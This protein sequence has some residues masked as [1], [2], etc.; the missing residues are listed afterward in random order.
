MV[1]LFALTLEPLAMLVPSQVLCF[2]RV[3]PRRARGWQM[4][5]P[6]RAWHHSACNVCIVSLYLSQHTSGTVVSDTVFGRPTLGQRSH[7][8]TYLIPPPA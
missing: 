3:P 6:W 1:L 8:F 5:C 2:S 7:S 4:V